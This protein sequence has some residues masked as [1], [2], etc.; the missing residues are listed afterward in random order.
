MTSSNDLRKEIAGRASSPNGAP[1]SSFWV[2][3]GQ[4]FLIPAG[5]V[6]VCVSLAAFMGWMTSGEERS[7]KEWVTMIRNKGANSR[8][9]AAHQLAVVLQADP[10]AAL[11]PGLAA[12]ILDAYDQISTDGVLKGEK[13]SDLQRTLINCVA[14]TKDTSVTD[15]ITEILDSDENVVVRAACMDV[16]GTVR[17]PDAVE[18]LAGYVDDTDPGL[19]KHAVLNLASALDPDAPRFAERVE[20]IRKRLTEDPSVEVAWNAAIGLA[21]FLGDPSGA[22]TLHRMLDRAYMDRYTFGETRT[23]EALAEHAIISAC[24]AAARLD[25]PSFLI[26]LKK[27]ADDD[28]S[29][30]VRQE[31][32]RAIKEIEG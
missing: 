7:A 20:A 11:E 25:D 28:R 24:R 3:A 21:W 30:L 15:R 22:D 9:F 14:M 31:A 16:L 1:P 32:R 13:K 2:K 6:A 8:G 19:R 18:A 12:A 26:P 4:L 10:K 29:I 23:K 27:L 5:L 17:G